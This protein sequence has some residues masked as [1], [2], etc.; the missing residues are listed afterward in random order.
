MY[1]DRFLINWCNV[2]YDLYFN[3]CVDRDFFLLILKLRVVV[4]VMNVFG[5]EYKNSISICFIIFEDIFL[6]FKLKRFD[7]FYE[8]VGIVVDKFVFKGDGF[9]S[10]INDIFIV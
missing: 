9:S 3:Y 4:V 10:M 5:L 8:V 7:I 6:F 2:I 1:L